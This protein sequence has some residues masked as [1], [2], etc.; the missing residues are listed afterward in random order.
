[1]LPSGQGASPLLPSRLS[2]LP[3]ASPSHHLNPLRH[4]SSLHAHFSRLPSPSLF[5]LQIHSP[6]IHSDTSTVRPPF[7]LHR[8]SPCD[9]PLGT[10][11]F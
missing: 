5:P 11:C 3:L 6:R 7:R 2:S 4:S 1:M 8:L 10:S 9:S